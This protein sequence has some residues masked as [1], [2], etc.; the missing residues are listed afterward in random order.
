MP[1]F[2][3]QLLPGT[4]GDHADPDQPLNITQVTNEQWNSP[5]VDE[6]GVEVSSSAADLNLLDGAAEPVAA[7]TALGFVRVARARFDAGIAANRTVAAHD[8]GVDLPAN[9]IVI[10][11]GYDVTE[12]FTSA[13]DS[14]T[15]AISVVG[16]NDVVTAT[17]ISAG[18]N[19]FDQGLHAVIQVFT[20]ATE[21]KTTAASPI[22][23]TVGTQA[24][25]AGAMDIW[26][27]YV[28]TTVN[29]A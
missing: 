20:A 15:M 6:D 21:I 22:V 9:V 8:L 29:A 3:S 11:G 2:Q 28:P 7:D 13:N 16:A 27:M 23:V 19:V 5:F 18:G 10:G 1:L 4:R 14:A 12:T 24:L 17:A 26:L 25:T